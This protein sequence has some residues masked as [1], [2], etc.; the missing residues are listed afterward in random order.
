[1]LNVCFAGLKCGHFSMEKF[2]VVIN[3]RFNP[4]IVLTVLSAMKLSSSELMNAIQYKFTII[5]FTNHW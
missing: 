4:L 5:G 3:S 1:M 2:T